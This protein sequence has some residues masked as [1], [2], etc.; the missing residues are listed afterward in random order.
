MAAND[1]IDET[2]DRLAALFLEHPAW[3]AAARELSGSATSTVY[4]SHRP[5]EAWRLEQRAGRTTLIPGKARDPDFIFRFTPASVEQ[6]ATIK[7]NIGAFAVGLFRLMGEEDE[8]LRVGFRI[9]ASFARLATRGYVKLLMAAGPSVLA[10]GARNGIFTL[11]A[12]R[13]LVTDQS[14]R[15]PADWEREGEEGA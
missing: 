11:G 12:L 15:A 14:S 3:L 7:G 9:G 10:F 5:G 8:H 2:I 4:F 13:R 1:S 6:L